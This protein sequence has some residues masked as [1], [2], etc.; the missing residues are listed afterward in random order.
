MVWGQDYT[1][2]AQE[3]GHYVIV[4]GICAEDG[5][6]HMAWDG[7]NSPLQYRISVQGIA[8]DPDNAVWSAQSFSGV[9]NTLDGLVLPSDRSD[10]YG[11]GYP[12]F[13]MIPTTG[14][15]QFEMRL[16]YSGNSDNWLFEYDSD[17]WQTVGKIAYGIVGEPVNEYTNTFYIHG[18]DYDN[19]GRM[20]IT[21][22]WRERAR[23]G[24]TDLE[25]CHDLN[26]VYSDDYG[27]TFYNSAG[28]LVASASENP[29]TQKT[30]GIIVKNIPRK[31]GIVNQEGQAVDSEGRIHVVI[32][33]KEEDEN[34]L[35][36]GN[37]YRMHYWRDHDGTWHSNK[38]VQT[39]VWNRGKICFDSEDRAYYIFDNIYIYTATPQTGWS[40]W[41]LLSAEDKG[42]VGAEPLIDKYALKTSDKLYIFAPNCSGAGTLS[43]IRYDMNFGRT[44]NDIKPV[45]VQGSGKEGFEAEAAVDDNYMTRWEAESAQD[46]QLEITFDGI[47][48]IN[49]VIMREALDKIS[50]YTIYYDNGGEWVLLTAGSQIGPVQSVKFADINTEKIRINFET[51]TDECASLF[52]IKIYGTVLEQGIQPETT[53]NVKIDY[54]AEQITGFAIGD[55]YSINGEEIIPGSA[56]VSAQEYMGQTISIIKKGN[57]VTTLDSAAQML[58]VPLRAQ[59]PTGISAKAPSADGINDGRILGVDNT[60]EYKLL[61]DSM[62]SAI[63][64]TEI[65]NL[66]PGKYSVRY[67][68]SENSFAS[69]ETRVEID[70]NG[71]QELALLKDKWKTYIIGEQADMSVAQIQA[72]ISNIDAQAQSYWESMIKSSQPDRKMIWADLSMNTDNAANI[73][74]YGTAATYQ[75][76]SEI[77][78]AFTRLRTLAVAYA[79]EGCVLYHN[80]E[81]KNEILSAWDLMTSTVYCDGAPLFGNWYHWQISGPCAFLQGML[82]MYEEISEDRMTQYIA[83]VNK[84]VPKS[85]AKVVEKAPTPTGANLIEQAM[86]VAMAGVLSENTEKFEDFKA[87]IKTTFVYSNQPG[88]AKDGFWQDGSYFQHS[89]IAYT[90]GYGAALY[91]KL[92]P[93]FYVFSDTPWALKYSDNAENVALDFI[94]EG[95]E[96]LIYDGSFMEMAAGRHVINRS[97]RSIA[98]DFIAYLL[99]FTDSMSAQN[100]ERLKSMLKYYISQDPEYFYNSRS[101]IF[102]LQQAMNLMED[103]TVSEREEYIRHKRYASMDKVSHITSRFGFGLSMHSQRT[104]NF[105]P[106]NDEGKRLWNVSDG[107]TYIYNGDKDQYNSSYWCTVDPRRL[108]GT[109]A[110]FVTRSAGAGA[111]SKNPFPFVGGTDMDDMKR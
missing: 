100:N 99:S 52:D 58:F 39:D 68:A 28:D 29:I 15:L 76:S 47:K 94:F 103:K 60:M 73:G 91:Q 36:S 86:N 30:P 80:E 93:F 66:A 6:I 92:A 25:T 87:A 95:I 49:T 64:G 101:N 8:N 57:G 104:S 31:S 9:L 63:S 46:Q 111:W 2:T 26:Y 62:W 110:E 7:W 105:G 74:E 24:I 43:V 50:A 14:K 34:G 88:E 5:T 11:F 72:C 108:S 67:A 69:L 70:V 59:A 27:R 38:I 90:G 44:I 102:E 32:R 61:S 13:L 81:L 56:G 33:H 96:P 35:F 4:M 106:M 3:D 22:S 17:G 1:R 83:A 71:A 16:G 54:A 98:S 79:T 107:M 97:D 77:V 23:T 19:N 51:E 85:T 55:K 40:D 109:T 89:T 12:R 45:S 78:T 53:P 65:T 75:E 41:T 42:K 21:W 20:H 82:A 37:T 18:I 48:T 10:N 84:F